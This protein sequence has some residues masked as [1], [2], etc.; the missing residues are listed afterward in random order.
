[1]RRF[2]A[3]LGQL[4]L[5]TGLLAGSAIPAQAAPPSGGINPCVVLAVCVVIQD[6]GS[7]G[8]TGSGGGTNGGSNGGDSGGSGGSE[9]VCAWHGVQHPC[10]DPDLGWFDTGSGCY[11]TQA[12]PQPPA[13]DPSWGGNTAADG[14]IYL[15]TCYDVNNN[16][17]STFQFAKKPPTIAAPPPTPG[18][19]AQ[20]AVK[21]LQFARP[22]PH[23]APSGQAVVGLPVWFWYETSDTTHD[24]TVGPQT[25]T[26]S[27]NGVTVSATATLVDVVWDL[28]YVDPGTGQEATLDCK[29]KG[30]GHPYAAGLEQNPPADA[31]IGQFGRTSP[32]G[33]GAPSGAPSSG[34][35]S[36]G[37]STATV[38]GYDLTVTEY[39]TITTSMADG[40]H[41][42]GPVNIEVSSAPLGLQVSEL[43][44]LN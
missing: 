21:K 32:A 12:D 33:A 2:P 34:A 1:M 16:A 37:G 42:W 11:I 29:G 15:Y 19:V 13:D 26:V 24:Q 28:G 43:Q 44:V 36:G 39:W 23:T 40:S 20:M 5:L 7:G 10:W 35:P 6:P 18:T 30:A 17:S 31:C 27:L 9:P 4:L 25:Q 22:I 41:P 14:A 8:S 3:L 38:N